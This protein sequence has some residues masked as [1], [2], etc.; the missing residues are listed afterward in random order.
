MKISPL[1]LLSALVSCVAAHSGIVPDDDPTTHY[2]DVAPAVPQESLPQGSRSVASA[3]EEQAT[4]PKREVNADRLRRGLAPNPPT[5]RAD[6]RL[7]PRASPVPCTPLTNNV[8]RIDVS[9]A[10]SGLSIGY[11]SKVYDG[12]KSYTFTTD[13]NNALTVSLPSL[14]PCNT[15]IDI[16]AVDGPDS[17]YPYVGAV[18]GSGGYQFSSTTF[19]YAYLSGTGHTPANSP[20]SSTAGHSIQSL[21]YNAPAESQIW[22]LSGTTHMFSAIWT[23]TDSSTVPATIYYDP[24]VDFIGLTGSLTAFNLMFPGEGAYAVTLKFIPAIE[25]REGR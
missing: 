12:Q 25:R 17:S 5:R 14:S 8:G 7:S 22:S 10:D 11:L 4:S 24:A 13:I 21:G 19:G 23:N 16:T 18:G 9:N 15:L 3:R 6:N 2:P 1:L 20:P